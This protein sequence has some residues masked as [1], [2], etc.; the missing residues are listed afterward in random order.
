MIDP[1]D[2]RKE[3][4]RSMRPRFGDDSKFPNSAALIHQCDSLAYHL[5]LSG[6]DRMTLIAHHALQRVEELMKRLLDQ[7]N[8]T[9]TTRI[10][11]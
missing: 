1:R 7:A 11:L 10:P 3:I 2:L 9:I 4:D 8:T 6:E 5:G